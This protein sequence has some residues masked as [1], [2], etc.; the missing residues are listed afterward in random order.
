MNSNSII[1]KVNKPKGRVKIFIDEGGARRLHFDGPNLVVLGASSILANLVATGNGAYLL[2]TIKIGTGST[3]SVLT[4]D[5]SLVDS[6]PEVLTLS[7][8]SIDELTPGNV[9]FSFTMGTGVGNG[10]GSKIYNEAGLFSN[11]GVMF[12]REIFTNLEKTNTRS[13]TWQ[14]TISFSG[15]F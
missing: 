1:S 11:G 7:S 5:V 9:T 13:I 12:A 2:D 6:A 10:G 15:S 8:Y 14:W 3:G 4:S